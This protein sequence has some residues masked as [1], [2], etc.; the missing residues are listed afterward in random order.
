MNIIEH[1]KDKSKAQPYGLRTEEEQAVLKKAGPANCIHATGNEHLEWSQSKH[2]WAGAA[3]I[4]KPDYQ[5]EPEFID[6]ELV[7]DGVFWELKKAMPG[8][9]AFTRVERA[10]IHQQF[11]HFRKDSNHYTRH[12]GRATD[13]ANE[14]QKVVARF[15]NERYHV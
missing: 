5:P 9:A 15:R 13:W 3:Y 4:L 1:L 10:P 14:G 8:C 11:V 12:A 2:T 7:L 6:I